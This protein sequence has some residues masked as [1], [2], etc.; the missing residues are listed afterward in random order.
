MNTITQNCKHLTSI[1][2]NAIGVNFKALKKFCKK[3]G[4]QLR[5]ISF[6]FY[7]YSDEELVKYLLKK[8]PNLLSIRKFNVKNI[9]DFVFKRLKKVELDFWP[10]DENEPQISPQNMKFLENLRIRMWLNDP[11]KV[12]VDEFA[13]LKYLKAL[14]IHCFGS[15]LKDEIWAQNIATIASNCIGLQHFDFKVK[16]NFQDLNPNICFKSISYFRGLKTLSFGMGCE[17]PITD[18]YLLSKIARV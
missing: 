5:H 15:K 6:Q 12:F 11:N 13:K 4:Q 14:K 1:D 16:T 9:N 2:F 17:Q 10:I 18:L 8:S 7:L 3:F